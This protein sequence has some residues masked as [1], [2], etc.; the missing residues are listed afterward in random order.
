MKQ[1][2]K[3]FNKIYKSSQMDSIKPVTGFSQKKKNTSKNHDYPFLIEF[4]HEN[5]KNEPKQYVH[6]ILGLPNIPLIGKY[7]GSGY[8]FGKVVS[9][10]IVDMYFESTEIKQ[11]VYQESKDIKHKL[12]LP[13]EV[14]ELLLNIPPQIEENKKEDEFGDGKDSKKQ[15]KLTD[16]YEPK[17]LKIPK[18]PAFFPTEI[19]KFYW[20]IQLNNIPLYNK[21]L[22]EEPMITYN[23]VM[24]T[25]LF[26]VINFEKT[27]R[28]VSRTPVGLVIPKDYQGHCGTYEFVES[29][30]SKSKYYSGLKLNQL[31]MEYSSTHLNKGGL[32][33][34]PNNMRFVIDKQVPIAFFW[35][36]VLDEKMLNNQCHFHWIINDK[37][38]FEVIENVT[39]IA[40]S[41][42]E[43]FGGLEEILGKD[44]DV[45]KLTKN[46]FDL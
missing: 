22:N 40:N 29:D 23:Y 46:I 9:L 44:N 32:C 26:P 39:K 3:Y 33:F 42:S 14:T 15:T 36:I 5:F 28:I 16:F 24:H 1:V 30:H 18:Q 43:L 13:E 27:K 6:E 38:L 20:S 45:I 11:W 2:L 35:T 41:L 8:E 19:V 34:S 4:E 17:S 37:N 25:L 7:S 10:A 31:R 21:K 12:N